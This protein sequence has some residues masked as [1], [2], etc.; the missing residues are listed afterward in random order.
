MRL[1]RIL[2]I[3]KCELLFL[4]NLNKCCNQIIILLIVWTRCI[5]F[6][7]VPYDRKSGYVSF[8]IIIRM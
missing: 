4:Q 2:E 5:S 7:F 8:W 6:W 1:Q 3:F